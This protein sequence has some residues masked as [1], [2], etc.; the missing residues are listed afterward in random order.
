MKICLTL[1]A[2]AFL[3][4]ISCAGHVYKAPDEKVILYLEL[5]KAQQVYFACSLDEYRLQKVNKM[6]ANRWE[7]AVPAHLEFRYF[8]LVDG[9]VYLPDCEYREAD[10]FGSENCIFVP[11]P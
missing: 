5:S 3:W 9:S 7:I 1:M 11:K 6:K 4:I 10:D 8:F 2:A